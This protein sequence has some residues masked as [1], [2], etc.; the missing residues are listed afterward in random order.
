MSELS[1]DDSDDLELSDTDNVLSEL[2]D[3]NGIGS[4]TEES[5]SEL[6]LDDLDEPILS[7]DDSENLE[8][9]TTVGPVV[10]FD[11]EITSIDAPW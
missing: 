7:L 10:L 6:S 8:K 11:Y 5:M 4:L 2:D 9:F 3:L 1:L